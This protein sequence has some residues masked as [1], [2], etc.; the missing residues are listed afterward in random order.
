WTTAAAA[1]SEARRLRVG[2]SAATGRGTRTAVAEAPKASRTTAPARKRPQRRDKLSKD[3]YR[4]QKASVEAELT[5]L[6]LRKSRLE[7]SLGD[8]SVTANYVEMRR[9]TSEL[10]DI[11]Q[12]LA[13]A[14]DAWLEV[15]ERAP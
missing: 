12:A 13:A 5:R 9:I 6:G 4:R 14:E 7:L 3:A 2:S 15:E 10:A 8:P 1:E 11:E